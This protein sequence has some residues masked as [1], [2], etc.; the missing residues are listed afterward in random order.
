MWP[1][2][3]VDFIVLSL[4]AIS[5][6]IRSLDDKIQQVED[7][8]TAVDKEGNTVLSH[9]MNE[10]YRSLEENHHLNPQSLE[11]YMYR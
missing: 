7:L 8:R 5:A 10:L 2:V 1:L 4:I 3:S 11:E 6:Y 9:K